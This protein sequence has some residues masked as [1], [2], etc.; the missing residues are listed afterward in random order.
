MQRVYRNV[1]APLT[2]GNL[3]VIDVTA[4]FVGF[5]VLDVVTGRPVMTCGLVMTAAVLLAL[6]KRRQAP[7][8][9]M[10]LARF[11]LLPAQGHVG[12]KDTL[13]GYIGHERH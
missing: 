10:N 13:P 11:L 9:T 5:I 8:Y 1:S 6:F 7:G 3:E 2:A 12:L 4:L